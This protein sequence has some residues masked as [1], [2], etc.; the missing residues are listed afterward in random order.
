ML[1]RIRKTTLFKLLQPIYHWL[2]SFVAA[3][4]YGFP[5]RSI[6]VI[7]VTG[8]KGKSTTTEIINAILTEAGNTTALSNTIRAK[9]ADTSERNMHKMTMPGRFFIQRFLRQAVREGCDWAILEM[10]SEGVRFFRHKWI[11]LDGLVFTNL[12]PEHIESHG[13]FENYRDA[14]RELGHLLEKSSKKERVVVANI[15]DEEGAWYL[16]RHVETSVPYSISDAEPQDG[17]TFTFRDTLITTPLLGIFNLYNI[18]AASSFAAHIGIDT[19]TIKRA[20]ENLSDIPGRVEF[21]QKD[22][23][24]VVV[25]YAHTIDSLT[26]FYEIF[27][28]QKNICILGN[29]GGGRDTWKR[30]KMAQ[31]AEQYCTH[32]ILTNEDPYDEDP[33]AILEM[34]SDAIGDKSKLE[35]ILDR[36]E[37]ISSAISLAKKSSDKVNILITGKG[38]DP[39]IMG[40]HGSKEPWDDKVVVREELKKV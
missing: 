27:K 19:Q 36:R 13:S 21:V 23:F 11:C 14:K 5:S 10:T 8:T 25:D 18:L 30:P 20:V 7:G 1:D 16:G 39:Y 15:D 24:S 32:V 17:Q 12:S 38:T 31:L 35:I 2:L 3:L 26:Q 29:T 28:G 9:I 22:P 6:R 34:M 33:K 4:V 37:A 40:P